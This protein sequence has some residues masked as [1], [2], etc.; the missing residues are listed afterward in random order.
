MLN[1]LH[2]AGRPIPDREIFEFVQDKVRESNGY[3][4]E[5]DL[6]PLFLEKFK[7]FFSKINN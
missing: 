4:Y 6:H 2:K 5:R 1:K 7:F 3:L